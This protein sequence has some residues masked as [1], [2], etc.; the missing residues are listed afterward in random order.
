MALAL[1][2]NTNS[3]FSRLTLL[4]KL[5]W[6][7]FLLLIFEGALRKWVAPQ[8]SA[9]LLIVRDPVGVLIISEAYRTGKWPMRWSAVIAGLAV[10]LVGLFIVQIV[11]GNNP[12][13]VGLYGLRSF[14]LPFPVLLIMGENLDEEDIRKIGALTLW[15]LMPMTLLEVAQYASPSS[16]FLNRGAYEGGAQIGY[17]GTKV[18]ASGTFSFVVGAISF[19]VLA[20]AFIFYGMVKENLAKRWLLWVDAFAL[21]LA[22]PMTGARG[23]VFLLAGVIAC[24]ALGAMMG[25]SHFAKAVRIILPLVIVSLLVSRLPVFSDALGNLTERFTEAEGTEEGNPGQTLIVR[26]ITPIVNTVESTDFG[27]NLMGIGLGRG[28][29]AVQALLHGTNEAVAG[30]NEVERE[31]A[32][33]GPL[34]GTIFALFKLFLAIAV[35]GQALAAA[36]DHEVLALLMIPL[37][38]SSLLFA[39]PEQPTEQGFMV[40]AMA[41]CIAAAKTRVQTVDRMLPLVL[42]RQQALA[43]RRVQIR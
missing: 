31:F 13:I 6:L 36:R 14:L 33:M 18:R 42:L 26:M 16:S 3:Y 39:T 25:V 40:I 1:K 32:E 41:L 35:F 2:R 37:A 4:K 23:F 43:R 30:E 8:L 15:L 7:Y 21:I 20:A 29:I 19:G 12:W 27:S 34:A 17:V 9:P 24:V 28:A 11:A 38:L 22:V 10:L 5:F